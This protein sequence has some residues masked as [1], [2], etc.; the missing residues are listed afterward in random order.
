MPFEHFEAYQA[1]AEEQREHMQ[2]LDDQAAMQAS[3]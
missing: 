3:A 1:A 2:S